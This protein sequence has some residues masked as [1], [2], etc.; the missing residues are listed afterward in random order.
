MALALGLAGTRGVAAA[1]TGGA[2]L[3]PGTGR[4]LAFGNA[5][6]AG[7]AFGDNLEGIGA[8]GAP[9]CPTAAP[10][11]PGLA[12]GLIE[13]LGGTG[14][15]PCRIN[16]A[17][18]AAAAGSA[19]P[20][21]AGGT[22]AWPGAPLAPGSP[23]VAPPLGRTLPAPGVTGPGCGGRLMTLLMTVVL[24][25]LAKMMLFGGGAT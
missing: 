12:A 13:A 8:F 18:C 7:S 19:G 3:A 22:A 5:W 10:E 1:G 6:P 23:G 24:W 11:M 20:A 25:M 14:S 15:F 2:P 9:F 17:F 4:A 16:E 21:P